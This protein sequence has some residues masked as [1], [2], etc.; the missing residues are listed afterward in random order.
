MNHNA[1]PAKNAETSPNYQA[2][3]DTLTNLQEKVGSANLAYLITP[4][5]IL[6]LSGARAFC[7]GVFYPQ[8][9]AELHEQ[10]AQIAETVSALQS[11]TDVYLTESGEAKSASGEDYVRYSAVTTEG[12]KHSIASSELL[13][14]NGSELVRQHLSGEELMDAMVALLEQNEQVK[15]KGLGDEELGH[16]AFGIL[17]G[18]P[19]KAIMSSI[20]KWDED[21]SESEDPLVDAKIEGAAFYT[22][23]QPVYS[24]PRSM[25]NDPEIVAHEKLWSSILT[26]FYESD[27]HKTL[28]QDPSFQAKAKQLGLNK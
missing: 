1:D 16:I 25:E 13:G 8:N 7:D 23:P 19:D 22:C 21:P 9:D 5:V 3:I 28:A 14:D 17:V 2:A 15:A 18:Y 20:D 12:L 26:S 6:T 27:F 10:K 24:Y 11:T 4:N